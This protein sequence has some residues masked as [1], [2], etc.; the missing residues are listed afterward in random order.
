M[1]KLTEN[2]RMNFNEWLQRMKEDCSKGF[3]ESIILFNSLNP[4]F[5]AQIY[6]KP[7]YSINSGKPIKREL[8]PTKLT[9]RQLKILT[10]HNL[11][12]K[13]YLQTLNK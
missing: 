2:Q 1:K 12:F 8:I 3:E 13:E 9:K 6:K 4:F 10:Y 11:T 5:Q 7:W